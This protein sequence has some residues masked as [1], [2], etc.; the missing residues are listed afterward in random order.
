MNV[1]W[2]LRMAPNFLLGTLFILVVLVM[3]NGLVGVAQSLYAKWLRFRTS[4]KKGGN[5]YDTNTNLQ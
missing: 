2:L 3:P 5:L 4:K 1:S